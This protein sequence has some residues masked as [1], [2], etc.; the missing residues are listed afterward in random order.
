MSD[1]QSRAKARSERMML[2]KTRLG[3]A[4]TDLSPIA[5]AE[6]ITLVS[7]LTR[8]SYALAGRPLPTYTRGA[9]PCR[10]VPWTPR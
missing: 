1:F 4:E 2:H 6:A 3:E 8:T 7:R 9:I 5:G 10:F